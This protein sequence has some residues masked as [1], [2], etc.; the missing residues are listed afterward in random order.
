MFRRILICE[1][2][3]ISSAILKEILRKN[4]DCIVTE[5]D[6][7]EETYKFLKKK[8]VE[9]VEYDYII[10]SVTFEETKL[11]NFLTKLY[12]EDYEAEI[13]LAGAIGLEDELINKALNLKIRKFLTK[14]YK[15]NEIINFL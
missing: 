11:F 8:K 12:D 6:D 5:F 3:K 9:N 2:Q 7:L 4:S 10:V 1:E 14:P 13:A 15:E